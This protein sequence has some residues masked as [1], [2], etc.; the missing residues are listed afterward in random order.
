LRQKA[1]EA[2]RDGT[3]G[4]RGAE[5]QGWLVGGKGREVIRKGFFLF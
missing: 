3:V 2:E 1:R 4:K 5:K